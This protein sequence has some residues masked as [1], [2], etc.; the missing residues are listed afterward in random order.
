[1]ASNNNEI[2]DFFQL[3]LQVDS[4][5][6]LTN[7]EQSVNMMDY[8]LSWTEV[9]GMDV[10]FEARHLREDLKALLN[11]HNTS[12]V[13]GLS[14]TAPPISKRKEPMIDPT[15]IGGLFDLVAPE[16]PVDDDVVIIHENKGNAGGS[17]AIMAR[18]GPSTSAKGKGK[19]YGP[20][21]RAF[22]RL[23]A[24]RAQAATNPTPETPVA[25]VVPSPPTTRRTTRISMKYYSMKLADRGGPS[26]V[27]PVDNDPIE[28]SSDS[29]SE[30]KPENAIRNLV[31]IEEE[32]EEEPEEDPEEDPE[33]ELEEENQGEE[34]SD[35]IYF[36][37]YFE[38][39][40][41][42]SSDESCTGPPPANI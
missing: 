21:T 31:E 16:S 7:I 24:L 30:L 27:A 22:P 33:E 4:D 37:N 2:D 5:T 32:P 13:K 9:L 25:P 23:A 36:A 38:L 42:N 35:E 19:A 12:R 28:V 39:A 6:H 17:V 29:E 14:M 3:S 41:A 40:P 11:N 10:K 26:N 8:R 18:N 20:P 34:Q 15:L 1:M